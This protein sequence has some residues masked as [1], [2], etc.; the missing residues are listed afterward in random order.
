MEVDARFSIQLPVC[1]ALMEEQKEQASGLSCIWQAG[2]LPS[3]RFQIDR[4]DR[5]KGILRNPIFGSLTT[6]SQG[7]IVVDP[8]SC[9]KVPKLV[10]TNTPDRVAYKRSGMSLNRTGWLLSLPRT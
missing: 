7:P 1:A 10:K 3:A 6:R 2:V 4:R 9:L 5:V 8:S